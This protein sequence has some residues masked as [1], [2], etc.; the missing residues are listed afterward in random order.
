[1]TT[2]I[3]CQHWQPKQTDPKMARMGFAQ[4][5]KKTKGH[6]YS[7]ESPVCDKHK[8]APEETTKARKDWLAAIDKDNKK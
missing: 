3:T 7:S 5:E 2:C 1:M 6:T 8:P 4:C